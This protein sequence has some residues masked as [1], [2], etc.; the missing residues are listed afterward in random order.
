MAFA[1]PSFTLSSARRRAR[2][3]RRTFSEGSAAR[4]PGPLLLPPRAATAAAAATTRWGPDGRGGSLLPA[5]AAGGGA[6]GLRGKNPTE[7]THSA[8]DA[9]GRDASLESPVGGLRGFP[10][11]FSPLRG[12]G[13]GEG[14]GLR[15]EYDD[16]HTHTD[17]GDHNRNEDRT[18]GGTDGGGGSCSCSNVVLAACMV[19]MG[20]S[21]FPATET[22]LLQSTMFTRCFNWPQYYGFALLALFLPGLPVQLALN[23]Y[24]VHANRCCGIQCAAALKLVLGHGLMVVPMCFFFDQLYS[25]HAVAS[26]PSH[27]LVIGCY[28]LIGAGCALVYSTTSELTGLMPHRFHAFFFIGT[29][30]VAV[31]M[32]PV[33]LSVGD[34]YATDDQGRCTSID[35]DRLATF[36]CASLGCNV[37]GVVAVVV[38]CCCTRAGRQATAAHGEQLWGGGAAEAPAQDLLLHAPE[39]RRVVPFRSPEPTTKLRVWWVLS[40][41]ATGMFFSMTGSMLMC[42]MYSRLPIAGQ[43]KS[44]NTTMLYAFYVSQCLGAATT[45]LPA[46]VRQLDARLLLALAMARLPV[47]PLFAWYTS[48]DPAE[49]AAGTAPVNPGDWG[50]LVIAFVDTWMGG[51]LFSRS[52]SLAMEK[53]DGAEARSK[54]STVMGVVYSGG[55]CALCGAIVATAPASE[56]AGP[57]NAT[58]TPY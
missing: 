36:Y 46:V 57:H 43:I 1:V 21:A 12:S 55:L 35:W 29:Y 38:L 41:E 33:N 20:L 16:E 56:A 28:T 50:V 47:V 40:R 34:L 26:H 23:R 39:G 13:D 14:G 30:M 7:T 22:L 49:V 3:R 4:R 9:Y 8:P 17:D 32:A 6:S 45:M 44:L 25:T 5:A 37:A 58:S 18:D 27:A 19:C 53:F 24:S 42:A 48:L 51:V 52:F 2:L 15:V 54:A 31:C 10:H 11:G